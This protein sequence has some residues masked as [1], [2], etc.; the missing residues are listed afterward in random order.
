MQMLKEAIREAGSQ[1]A[2]A[3]K[4]N[5]SRQYLTDVLKSRRSLSGKVLKALGLEKVIEFRCE[6]KDH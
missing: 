6:T 1:A 5:I 2:F 4:H 3:D